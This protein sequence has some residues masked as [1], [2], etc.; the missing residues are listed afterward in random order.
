MLSR[1]CSAAKVHVRKAQEDRF[2]IVA[3]GALGYNRIDSEL[4]WDARKRPL[5]ENARLL[6]DK[7]EIEASAYR[8]AQ[9]IDAGDHVMFLG[10]V[11]DGQPPA[12]GTKPLMYF[13]RSYGTWED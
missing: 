13:R 11:E 12:P 3:P 5:P 7:R 4:G 6:S 9:E 2:D 10:K 1:E 8:V